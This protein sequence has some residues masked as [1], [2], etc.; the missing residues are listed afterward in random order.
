M[1]EA[2]PRTMEKS[3]KI[4]RN[5]NPHPR[6]R[7]IRHRTIVNSDYIPIQHL[8]KVLIKHRFIRVQIFLVFFRGLFVRGSPRAPVDN[9]T[10]DHRAL[11]PRNQ[12]EHHQTI[13]A[14]RRRF[15]RALIQKISICIVPFNSLFNYTSRN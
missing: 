11:R 8:F 7:S 3:S 14:P 5:H 4:H 10:G 1:L 9:A 15:L 6:P 12:Q 13:L 2:S